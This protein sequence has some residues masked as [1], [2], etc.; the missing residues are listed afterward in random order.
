MTLSLS[1]LPTP[2]I[3]ETLDFEALLSERKAALLN[4]YPSAEDVLDNESE[5]LNYLLQESCYRELILRQRINDSVLAITLAYAT[6][7]DLDVIGIDRFNMERLTITEATE[8]D[9]AV[10]ESDDDYRQR[11]YDSWSQQSTAGPGI[12][13]ESIARDAD[14]DV[15]AAR[16]TSPEPGRVL[17]SILS[18]TNNG[19]PS[20]ELV[21]T[22]HAA[23]SSDD[24]RPLTVEVITA[25]AVI[26]PVALNAELVLI[27]GQDS[28]G[29]SE[30]L[31]NAIDAAQAYAADRKEIGRDLEIS[32]LYSLLH[33]TGVESVHLNSPT[34]TVAVADNGAAVITSVAVA[35]AEA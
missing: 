26:T 24:S 12:A 10:M 22:V 31:A 20:Q 16:A 25:P 1:T 6:G 11:I 9:D 8:T 34:S 21:A 17:V 35:L 2:D 33:V 30:I 5:P 19:S 3:I 32:Q 23:V 28:N 4:L 13:Y 14:G 27:D 7:A 29:A 18:H 15:A